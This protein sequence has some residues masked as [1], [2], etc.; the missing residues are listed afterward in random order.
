M[1]ITKNLSI[2]HGVE[3][4]QDINLSLDSKA[5]KR[6]AIVGHNGCGKSTLLQTLVGNHEPVSGSIHVSDE[7]VGYLPQHIDL[8]P[9]ILIGEYLESK[10]AE[11]W[12]DYLIDI[13][14]NQVGLPPEII[15]QTAQSLSGG[16]KVRLKLAEILLSEPTILVLDEPTNHL[17]SEGLKWFQN[18]ISEFNGSIILVSHNRELLSNS[19]NTIWEM[20]SQKKELIQ[21]DGNYERWRATRDINRER[22]LVVFNRINKEITSIRQWLK[23]HEF[24]PKY[25]FSDI[26]AGQKKKLA[27]LETKCPDK[28]TEAPRI[29]MKTQEDDKKPSLL[30]KFDI[31]GK[32]FEGS[33]K[34]LLEGV[35]GKIRNGEIIQIVGDNG[36]GKT[37]LIKILSLKDEAF[38]GNIISKENLSISWLTQECELPHKK[39]VWDLISEHSHLSETECHR[40]LSHYRLKHLMKSRVETLSGGEQKRLELALILQRKPDVL[41]LDEPTNHL[42][43]YAQEDLEEFLKETSTA[44]VFISHDEY[45]SRVLN[46]DK[47]IK[48]V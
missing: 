37:T 6:I 11:G 25:R 40:L 21:Y 34:V 4:V 33:Q 1:F 48:L 41:F 15:L 19:I 9:D 39:T 14:L 30:I 24:H 16:Q 43:I 7:Y 18:F 31:Q 20:D 47:I 46:P 29:H 10:L 42:D 5:R 36:T 23:A 13:A 26:V 45:F 12:M 32:Q 8:P 28:P 38:E 2:G 17:D 3:D 22:Q 35:S 44:I 27:S